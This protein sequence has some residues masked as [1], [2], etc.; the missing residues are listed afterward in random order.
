[1][2]LEI[3]QIAH[4][5]GVYYYRRGKLQEDMEKFAQE[6]A[7]EVIKLLE[8]GMDHQEEGKSADYHAGEIASLR[9]ARRAIVEKFGVER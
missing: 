4:E 8:V 2:N 5:A 7:K 6:L 3:K 9:W 1:M